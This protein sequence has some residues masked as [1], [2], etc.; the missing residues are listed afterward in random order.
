MDK[1]EIANQRIKA[2]SESFFKSIDFTWNLNHTQSAKSCS[3]VSLVVIIT[4]R[5]F[6]L[7]NTNKMGTGM[8]EQFFHT[9]KGGVA[10]RSKK[11]Y[12]TGL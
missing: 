4:D 5:I 1:R 2:L 9:F 11:I 3:Q 12:G 10:M 7:K 6:K 8:N